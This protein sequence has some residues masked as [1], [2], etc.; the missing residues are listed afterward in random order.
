MLDWLVTFQ[1]PQSIATG[2]W[3]TCTI[4]EGDV[5]CWG[6]E[7]EQSTDTSVYGFSMVTLALMND[8]AMPT[9]GSGSDLAIGMD[10]LLRKIRFP[11][12]EK[13]SFILV[14][15]MSERILTATGMASV[16]TVAYIPTG[17]RYWSDIRISMS[18]PLLKICGLVGMQDGGCALL[19]NGNI[20]CWTK[21]PNVAFGRPPWVGGYHS[22]E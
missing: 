5:F 1:F 15:Y 16:R 14:D 21:S 8:A 18:P 12:D 17:I 11:G 4:V 9:A 20:Q 6:A 2:E 13:S 22:F 19:A 7:L 3:R 10:F